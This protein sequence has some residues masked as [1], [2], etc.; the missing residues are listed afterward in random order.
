MTSGPLLGKI[1][2]F[3]LPLIASG[4]LQQSFNVVDVAVIGNF[5]TSHA[6]AAVGS[7][8]PVISIIVNLFLGIAV[9][10]NAVIAR[11]I[12]EKRLDDVKKSVST[13]AIV[14][15]VSGLL[16]V[17]LGLGLSRPILEAMS[18]PQD[19]ID[20]ASQYL[21]IY[22]C[23]MPFIMIYNFG[24]SILR[25][26]GDTAK[27][28]YSLLVA[29]VCN[30]ALDLLFVGVFYWGV[31][32]VAWATV[33]ANAVNAAIIVWF[34]KREP[35]PYKLHLNPRKWEM[36]IPALNE[37]LRIGIPAGLQGMVFSI[38]NIFIQSAINKFGA[39]AI[40]GSS[41]GLTFETYCYY[42]IVGLNGAAI[43]F[44]SQNY[45]AGL[46][47]RCKRV[48]TISLLCGFIL[49]GLANVFFVLNEDWAFRLFTSDPNVF[50]YASIRLHHVL[51]FQ[52]LIATYEISGSY[53]RGLGYSVIPMFLTIF[54]TCV[55]R[56]SWIWIFPHIANSFAML[57]NIYP[58]TWVA[59]GIFVLTA[60]FIVQHRV[61]KTSTKV[62]ID[63]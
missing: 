43:A 31:P 18:A 30:L 8:G 47:D 45:G 3:S 23:G 26:T 28:F 44:T 11:Y 14:S 49:C 41:V 24:G 15:L 38:S 21:R 59:T 22:F 5:S 17:L 46:Q 6:I 40:A 50:P 29:T 42:I 61:F 56:L 16:L 33:I 62:R 12:G 34:L 1:L 32:G 13:V 51:L 53:M 2:L 39:D 20:L 58:I 57:L 36:S 19:V 27:L 48:W 35:E 52:S 63:Y 60:A 7:N 54:G 9:G 4:I 37:M 10:A 55:L 25:S